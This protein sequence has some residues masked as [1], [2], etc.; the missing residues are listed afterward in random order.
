MEK[1]LCVCYTMIERRVLP[2]TRLHFTHSLAGS[3]TR[4]NVYARGRKWQSEVE[5]ER[6]W[7][8]FADALLYYRVREGCIMPALSNIGQE[9][10][11]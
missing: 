9:K 5:L 1:H 11:W 10:C 4:Q 7:T 2:P 6:R 3:S 8:M